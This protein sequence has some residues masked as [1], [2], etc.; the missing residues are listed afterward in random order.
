MTMPDWLKKLLEFLQSS[1]FK[2]I[3]SVAAAVAMYYLPDKVDQV[4]MA[5]LTAL[6]CSHLV[7][8]PANN[9]NGSDEDDHLSGI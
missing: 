4:I 8:V 9:K 7:I 2:G 5:V 1:T 3:V 6:G